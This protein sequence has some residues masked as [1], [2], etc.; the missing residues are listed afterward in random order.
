MRDKVEVTASPFATHYGHCFGAERGSTTFAPFAISPLHSKG[1]LRTGQVSYESTRSLDA[2]AQVVRRLSEQILAAIEKYRSISRFFRE[3]EIVQVVRVL[4]DCKGSFKYSLDHVILSTV[5]ELLLHAES[6]PSRARG[7][8]VVQVSQALG[9]SLVL[10][11][12]KAR[13]CCNILPD[14]PISKL[15][16]MATQASN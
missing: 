2:S 6:C 7:F 10:P 15:R 13:S 3:A 5:T 4:D 1:W 16:R 8:Y 12:T 14:N 9:Q 11:L